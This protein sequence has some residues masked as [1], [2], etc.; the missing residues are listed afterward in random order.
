MRWVEN[1]AHVVGNRY[2]K[3]GSDGETGKKETTWE[4]IVVDGILILIYLEE[5]EWDDEDFIYLAQDKDEGWVY[6]NTVMAFQVPH[7][8]ENFFTS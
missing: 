4:I 6:V 7:Y 1:V 3:Q 2:A 5:R 8:V